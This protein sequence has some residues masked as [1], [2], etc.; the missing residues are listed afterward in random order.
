MPSVINNL[1]LALF[2]VLLLLFSNA[3]FSAHSPESSPSP[4]PHLPPEANSSPPPSPTFLHSPPAPPPSAPTPDSASP[5][6]SKHKKSQS[7]APNVAAD[8]GEADQSHVGDLESKEDSSGM[9][10]GK[11]AGI[12][13]GVIGGG[14]V[15]GAAA[16]LYKK[17]QQNI[18]RAQYGYAARGDY[19]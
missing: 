10:G 12:A 13:I 16:V 1:S 3:A 19:M 14:C 8:D 17:R 6:P 15:V 9:S 7:S 11:K 18:R 4:S 2:S 5:A